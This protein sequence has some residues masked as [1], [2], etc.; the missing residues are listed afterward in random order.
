MP[1]QKML[2]L[3]LAPIVEPVFALKALHLYKS[4]PLLSGQFA[5]FRTVIT[6][7]LS[8]GKGFQNRR[9]KPE[10]RWISMETLAQ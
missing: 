9:V 5:A 3:N 8:N 1:N 7:F 6:G 4:S 2:N 10:N